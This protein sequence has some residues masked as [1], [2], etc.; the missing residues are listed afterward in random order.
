MTDFFLSGNMSGWLAVI[1]ASMLPIIE[2]RGAIPIGV[3][4]GLEPIYSAILAILGST[5]PVPFIFAFA[6]PLIKLLKQSRIFKDKIEKFL[7]RTMKK[8]EKIQKYEFWGLVIFVGIPLPG[9]G[10]WTGALLATLLDIRF[11][12]ATLAIFLGNV[13]AGTIVFT[14]TQLTVKSIKFIF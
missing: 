9:T 11:K 13:L 8:S 3:T 6:R 7:N 1:I 5:I 10:A 2:L 14:I 4:L 12:R